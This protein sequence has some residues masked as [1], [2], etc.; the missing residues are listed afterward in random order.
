[1]EKLELVSIDRIELIFCSRCGKYKIGGRWK[2]LEFDEVIKNTVVKEVKVDER[3]KIEKIEVSGK[4]LFFTGKFSGENL[5]LSLPFDYK[6]RVVCC[7]SCSKESGRYYEAVL[8][9]RTDGRELEKDEIERA[10]EIVNSFEFVREE[11]LKE[12]IDFYFKNRGDAKKALRRIA[13]EL[14]GHVTETKKLHTKIDGRD[15]YRS[16]YLVRL[17]SY[18]VGD[19]VQIKGRLVLVKSKRKGVDILS[20]KNVEIFDA[21]LVAKREDMMRGYV[22]DFDDNVAEV[23]SDSGLLIVKKPANI[24]IGSKVFIFEYDGK[25]YSFEGS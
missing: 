4:N 24:K 11:K 2:S 23:L 5:R 16:T 3:F 12:G 22:V 14:G 15:V 9:L 20:G 10:R 18:R 8:Q 19:V 7:P 25:F 6:I 13:E 1:M 17:P 21:K